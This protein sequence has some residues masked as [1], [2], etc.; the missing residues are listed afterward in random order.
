MPIAG[1]PHHNRQDEHCRA[2]QSLPPCGRSALTRAALPGAEVLSGH[3]TDGKAERDDRKKTRLDDA[4]A[5]AES[6]LCRCAE[7]PRHGID[8]DQ[9]HRHHRELG[10]G[11]QSD[12]QHACPEVEARAA[13]RGDGT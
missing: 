4:Q 6:G 3:G 7:R 9:I 1:E 13:S 10:A 12:L 11:G 2:G 8:E 5:D